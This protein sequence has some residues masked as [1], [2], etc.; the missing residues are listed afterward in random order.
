MGSASFD[1]SYVS[2][3]VAAILWCF[4]V[5]GFTSS[6]FARIGT[7]TSIGFSVLFTPVVLRRDIALA[8]VFFSPVRCLTA[9]ENY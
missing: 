8:A 1:W 3:S 4:G 5:G 2:L 9:N 7:L 6:S